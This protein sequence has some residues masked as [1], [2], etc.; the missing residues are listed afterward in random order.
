MFAWDQ[1][2]YHIKMFDLLMMVE[3][4]SSSLMN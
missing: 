2:L 1:M 4:I 3:K